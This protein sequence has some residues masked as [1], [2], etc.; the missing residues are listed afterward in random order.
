LRAVA[1]GFTAHDCIVWWKDGAQMVPT[2]ARPS[3]TESYRTVVA[4]AARIAAASA[5]TVILGGDEPKSVIAD[6]L[7]STPTEVSGLVAI[8]SDSGRRF[9]SAERT[10][11]K[12]IAM[13]LT[14]ELSWLTSHAGSSP[15][16][17]A[18]SQRA[19]TTR[20]RAR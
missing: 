19:C 4:A 13:R 10:D 6:A 17:S 20:C 15:K 5:G 11:L 7:R 1:E 14:R 8:I 3:P 18:C 9:S 2:S 12:A 16:A